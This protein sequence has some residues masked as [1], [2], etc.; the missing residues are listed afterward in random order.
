MKLEQ[1]NSLDSVEYEIQRNSLEYGTAVNSDRSIPDAKSGLKPV[2]K[3][4]L[5][6]MVI[7]G[8][9]SNKPHVKCAR[10]VGDVMGRLHPHGDSSIYGALIRLSQSWI[11]RYPLIDIHGNNGTVLGDGPAAMRYT[12]S[13]LSKLAE[14]GLLKNLNKRVV[15]FIPNYD[16]TDE[17]PVTLPAIFPNLLCNPNDGIG[18]ALGCSWAPHN[19]R[20]VEVA[21]NEYIDGKEITPLAPDFPTGGLIINKNDI[22]TISLSGKGSVKIRGQYNVENQNIIFYEIPYGTYIENLM[23]QIGKACD[24]EKIKDVKA[25]RNETGKKG[26]KLVIEVA[27]NGNIAKVINQLFEYTDLQ[28]TFSY[29]QVA[30]VGKT[31]TDLTLYDALKIYVDHNIDCIKKEYQFDLNKAKDRLEIVNG[32]LIALG[33]IDKVI[34]IIKQ[35]NSSADAQINLQ[36]A[37]KLTPNQTQAIV[38]MKLARLAKLGKTE[39]E[40]EQKELNLKINDFQDILA[41]YERQIKILKD[42][43]HTIVEQ[44][45]DDRRTKLD[46]I[47]VTKEEK[48]IIAVE[49]EKVVVVMTAANN[50][51][52]IPAVSF[53]EQKRNGKGMKIQKDDITSA[54]IR[55]NTVDNLLIFT[56]QGKV[57]KLLVDD[58]PVGTNTSTGTPI[59]AL[60]ELETNEEPEVIYSLYRDT[61]AKFIAYATSKGQIKKTALSEFGKMRRKAGATALGLNDGDKLAAVTLINDEDLILLSKKGQLLRIKSEFSATGKTAKGVKGMNV[62][63]DDEVIAMLPIRDVNDDLAIFL[64]KGQGKR[65]KLSEFGVTNRGGKGVKAFTDKS[66]SATC[67]CM[68]NDNDSILAAGATNTICISGKDV[69]VLGR[70]AAGNTIIKGDK[71][72]N[73]TKI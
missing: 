44:Y 48:E 30:L 56:N 52:R 13:R 24:E 47:T 51:K 67:A 57:Y 70:T 53:K 15:D 37:Y 65:I 73:I 25:V 11:M 39:L 40:D 31:P 20:E 55:T 35:S 21:I 4:I 14:D 62:S 50:I 5:Y 54:V 12:E 6:D 43:L 2:A 26:L 45:G 9:V 8:R 64:D 72:L 69:P 22:P 42:R 66:N 23:E 60:I 1:L 18:W 33:D 3:R 27:K 41:K 36:N 58:I 49:P 61:Q 7:E 28:T 29:N 10:V 63:D 16:D 71:V 19:L 59:G 46:Q 32:L 17:E 38:D 68:L 34:N